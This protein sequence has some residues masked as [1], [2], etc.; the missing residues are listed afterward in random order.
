MIFEIR[1]FF[2]SIAGAPVTGHDY[3]CESFQVLVARYTLVM[4]KRSRKK[5]KPREKKEKG[6][7]GKQKLYFTILYSGRLYIL[8]KGGGGT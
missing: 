5:K 3:C 1:V 4:I 8:P 2:F 7:E 6:L